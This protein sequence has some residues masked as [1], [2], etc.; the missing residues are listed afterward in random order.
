MTLP[1]LVVVEGPDEGAEFAISPDGGGIGRG[2][3]N[4]VKLTDMAVSRQH[5]SLR[6]GDGAL[7]VED[8][9]S[10]NR[11]LVNG[12]QISSHRLDEGDEI[13]VGK[14]RLAF[15]PPEGGVAVLPLAP[16]SLLTIEV[17]KDE[18]LRAKAARGAASS[19]ARHLAEL[20]RL[21]D[22]LRRTAD[23]GALLRLVCEVTRDALD[24]DRA[25]LLLPDGANRLSPVAVA[26]AEDAAQL[27]LKRDFVDRCVKGGNAIL[28]GPDALGGPSRMALAVPLD[29]GLL[30]A[31]KNL[32]T[33]AGPTWAE[34]DLMFCACVA[35][36]CVAGLEG[37]AARETLQRENRALEE[38]FGGGRELIGKGTV[39]QKMLSFVGK[40]G[41]T[42]STVLLLGES[43][44]GKEMVASA[45]H[46]A[47]RRAREPFIAVSC[48]ALTE[49]LLESE[50]FGHEKGSFTGATEKKLGRFELADRGTLF[51]DEVG[52]LTPRCQTKLLRVLEE[53]RF[54]R[55]GGQKTIAVDVRVIAATNRD[56]KGMVG[57]GGFREDLYYR[58]SVIQ[59]EVP[60]LRARR[61]DIQA[62]AEHFLEKLRLQAGR[63]VH[64]FLPEAMRALLAY[65]WP[66]NVRELRNAV[67]R[68]LVLGEGELIRLEDLPHEVAVA[69]PHSAAAPPTAPSAFVVPRGAAPS[70]AA[71]PA[72]SLR[73]LEKQGILAA[74]S[75]TS[76]NKAQAAAILEIDRSTLYKKLKEYGIEG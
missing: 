68:A 66:G 19:A 9:G 61:D 22:G 21:G 49:S 38:R 33:G 41:P 4:A 37:V 29:T 23:R 32:P 46:Y 16:A 24:A 75:Q 52:E 26:G 36:F 7:Y 69:A 31:E 2:E 74:L 71:Q 35:H 1:R 25:V 76:G 57:G 14:T 47:S 13:S 64:G 28:L 11:T 12:K 10:R 8:V 58:L 27:A 53:R 56:L 20:A 51:L 17:S 39:T 45:I 60:P 63:R 40:V 70:S 43:G 55:V 15:L 59:N 73:E 3:G 44:S 48:A 65:H 30:Y 62:L 42:D 50:L 54:E 5:C 72:A 34:P 67:E 18:L 6:F